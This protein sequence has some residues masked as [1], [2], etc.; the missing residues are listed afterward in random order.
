MG[1]EGAGLKGEY[2]LRWDVDSEVSSLACYVVGGV[3]QERRWSSLGNHKSI[4]EPPRALCRQ[5]AGSVIGVSGW[6]FYNW[7]TLVYVLKSAIHKSQESHT[8]ELYSSCHL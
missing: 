4:G 6:A 1:E 5:G 3:G 2:H 8:E 7:G